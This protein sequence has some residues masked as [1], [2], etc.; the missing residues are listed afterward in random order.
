[1]RDIAW[2]GEAFRRLSWVYIGTSTLQS[3]ALAGM[4]IGTLIFA[5]PGS[6]GAC[7]LAWEELIA[8]QLDARTLPCQFVP[9]LK[10][11]E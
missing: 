8:P 2:F 10:S 3:R 5:V 9:H 6:T 11:V 7:R 1:D 4:A